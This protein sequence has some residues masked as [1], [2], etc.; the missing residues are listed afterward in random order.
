[1][2]TGGATILPVASGGTARAH[3][4]AV[5]ASRRR[6]LAWVV[7][8]YVLGTLA[9]LIPPRLLGAIVTAVQ[10][11][12]TAGH[13][14]ILAAVIAAAFIAQSVLIRFGAL[15]GARLGEALLAAFREEFVD[16]VLALP[17][18]VVE[19]AGSG[20]LLSR[21]SRDVS[22]LS[23]AARLAVPAMLTA[24]VSVTLTVG[25]IALANPLLVLPCLIV[26]PP[27][28]A[29]SRWY[30]RRAPDGYRRESAAWAV[31]TD[32]L[33]ETVEGARTVDA[34]RLGPQRRACADADIAACYAAER[35]TLRLRTLFFPVAEASYILPVAGTLAFGGYA[36]LRGWCTLG[37]VTAATLYARALVGPL[38]EL[39]S[40]ADH[41]QVGAASLARLLGLAEVA[42]D[43]QAGA[44]SPAG[45]ELTARDVSHSYLPGHE[46]LSRISLD[47]TPGERVAI[48]GPSGAGKS[49]LG[50]LIAGICAPESGRIALG[51]VPLLE[52]PLD[53][54]RGEVALVTQEHHIFQGTLAENLTLGLPGA[55]DQA[56]RAALAAVDALGWAKALPAGLDTVVGSGGEA[57]SAPQAQQ[58]A[59]ARLILA[60]PHTLILDEATSLLDPRSARRL[61]QSLSV[62][63]AGRTVVAI[64]HRLHTAHDADRV[65]VMEEGRISESGTH[66]EL[67]LAAGS[68]AA[69]WDS[70]HGRPDHQD[71]GHDDR[72]RPQAL[73]NEITRPVHESVD[74]IANTAA[75]G[76]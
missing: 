43:R 69:L 29:A 54:L 59:L 51:G 5:L 28:W 11:G 48:V 38:D 65:I 30:L 46:V 41:L 26:V 1:M 25:A 49:T 75:R 42:P 7:A 10:A 62:V 15:A 31:M 36:Y 37:Q 12:T 74:N 60:D 56:V 44:A 33:A 17:L 22:S 13:L 50:R 23:M 21:S 58:V 6:E 14:D 67:I 72:E 47:I 19:R 61:E 76:G 45:E 64:A 8:L 70:W 24:A 40:W 27:V 53:E 66:R 55:S 35:Y 16:R 32:S 18:S 34:L 57:L 4:R 52:L 63:L 39:I 20:D 68:Y 9:G 71:P 2:T 73:P 3:A